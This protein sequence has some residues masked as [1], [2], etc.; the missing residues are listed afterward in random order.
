ML[1]SLAKVA[2]D[3][4]GEGEIRTLGDLRLTAFRVRRT[5]P[6]CDLSSGYYG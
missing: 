1:W 3:S 5:R 4:G 2:K 6:L